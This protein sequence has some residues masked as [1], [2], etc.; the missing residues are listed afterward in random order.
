LDLVLIC[1][2]EYL[3]AFV[4]VVVERV[5]VCLRQFVTG[6]ADVWLKPINNSKIVVCS[7]VSSTVVARVKIGSPFA[8]KSLATPLEE[9]SVKSWFQE[10]V[11]A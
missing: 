9:E 1:T 2:R 11:V 5:D 3:I 6:L 8:K 7:T 4:V 10:E